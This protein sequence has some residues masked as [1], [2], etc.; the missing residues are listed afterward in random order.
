MKFSGR[1]GGFDQ[2][3]KFQIRANIICKIG[4]PVRNKHMRAHLCTLR[5]MPKNRYML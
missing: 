3:D 5:I 4:A 1:P 2:G